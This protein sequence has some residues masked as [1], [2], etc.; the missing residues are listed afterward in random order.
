M[1]KK[2]GQIEAYLIFSEAH[3]TWRK[4]RQADMVKTDP[5]I[6]AR[7][8]HIWTIW[9]KCRSSSVAWGNQ[10]VSHGWH[11][12]VDAK[13]PALASALYASSVLVSLSHSHVR[14]TFTFHL[15]TCP[16][17]SHAQQ[18]PINHLHC[19]EQQQTHDG[20]GRSHNHDNDGRKEALGD[21]ESGNWYSKLM[22]C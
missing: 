20:R 6:I 2:Y 18:N 10:R 19:H 1:K 17:I 13:G 9:G 15:F 7:T 16:R 5:P 21:N 12:M 11:P 22:F 8:G 3:H 4:D 14:F